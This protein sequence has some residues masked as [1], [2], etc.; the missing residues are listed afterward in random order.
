MRKQILF[1]ILTFLPLL[2]S[3]EKSGTCGEKLTWTYEETT[4]TLT[5]SGSGE[6]TDYYPDAPWSKFGIQTAV[7]E[8]GVT[9]IGSSA[10]YNSSGLTTVTIGNSVTNI[11]NNAFSYCI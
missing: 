7:I 8:S 4:K 9:S 11:G 10:F 3:A 6:M 2:A 5:I 1:F